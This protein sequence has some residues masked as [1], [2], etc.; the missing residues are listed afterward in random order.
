MNDFGLLVLRLAGLGLALAH[1]LGKLLNLAAG[2]TGFID[3]VGRM[4][5]P[6]PGVFAWAAALSEVVGGLLVF[7]GL[8]TRVAAAFCAI[9]MAVAALGRHHAHDLLLVKLGLLKVP[10]ENLQAWGNPELALLYVLPFVAL[11]LL[12]GG[13][14]ALERLFKKGGRR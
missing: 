5:F 1:G 4:G 11:V 3:S 6:M 7:L 13:Q 2:N 8:G 10:P 14:Y 12:G 9:T